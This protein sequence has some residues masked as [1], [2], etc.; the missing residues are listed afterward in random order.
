ME[1][2]S[3]SIF[4]YTFTI[5]AI[6]ALIIGTTRRGLLKYYGLAG[7]VFYVYLAMEG[8]LKAL[9]FFVCFVV[10]QIGLSKF[11]CELRHDQG[12]N[13]WHYRLFLGLSLMPLVVSKISGFWHIGIFSFLGIS[14]LTFRGL[15]M[16]IEIYDGVIKDVKMLDTLYFLIFFPSITSGPI[17]RSRRFGDDLQ[18]LEADG[19]EAY[20]DLYGRG[21]FKI[22]LGA[23]Y[24]IVLAAAFYNAIAMLGNKTTVES[25][26]IYMY[27]YG[28]YLFFDFAGY[29][30]MAVGASYLIGIRT[31]D[32]FNKPFISVDIK[33][34]WDRWH[35]TL[36]YWFRD[37]LFS[38]FVMASMK[39]KW[40][41]NK[42]TTACVAFMVNMTVMGIWHG[43][44]WYYIVYG[45]Y[46]GLLLSINE[47]YQKK[48][49]FYKKHKKKTWYKVVSWF[50]TF[51]LVM[52]GFYIFSGHIT[53]G[54]KAIK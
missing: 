10:L 23:F 40:F 7:S 44:D 25:Q 43:L 11:Y 22:F 15:Q 21:L 27:G 46:H 39:G 31:P 24:K 19:R 47:V 28:M 9:I 29:S 36:S 54:I 18:G 1:L 38:R 35:M 5:Y 26:L 41:K 17:D 12:R 32:N 13:K 6:V 20:L 45:V 48:C 49:K 50:I 52:F 33:E 8:N 30:L 53:M 3:D 42:L 4:F 34:F 16:I 37:F 2:F 14:Y 51:N